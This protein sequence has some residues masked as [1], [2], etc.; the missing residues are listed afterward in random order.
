MPLIIGAVTSIIVELVRL[1]WHMGL[2]E[3]DDV[4]HN[5]IGMMVGYA[6][7]KVW[8]RILFVSEIVVFKKK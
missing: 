6:I 7:V 8:R 4:V 5:T 1:V 3:L 2:C